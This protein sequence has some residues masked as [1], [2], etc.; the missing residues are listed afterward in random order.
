MDTKIKFI[1]GVIIV[2]VIAAVGYLVLQSKP[3]NQNP[4][5]T[6]NVKNCAYTIEGKTFTLKNGSSEEPIPN[7]S[8][9]IKTQYFGNEVSSDFN[10]DGKTDAAF[11]LT[12]D[13]AGSGTFY[14]IAAALNG[15]DKCNGTNAFLLG[16]RIAPQTTQFQNGEIIVNYADRKPNE[17]MTAQPSVGVSRH[18]KVKGNSL[19]EILKVS[20]KCDNNKTINAVFNIGM[21]TPVKPGEQ[22][23]PNGSVELALSD[24]RKITL[25]QTISASGIRYANQNESLIFWN[26]GDTAFVQE[27][28]TETYKNCA[29]TTK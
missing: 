16:D 8:A 11:I 12:Q 2:L 5:F 15:G 25:P 14:F 20:L 10:G 28:G 6:L 7:S 21:P 29:I 18:F 1:L 9:K 26:K 17:P 23:I 3:N 4:A 22:P 27:N 13:L 24:G 19:E